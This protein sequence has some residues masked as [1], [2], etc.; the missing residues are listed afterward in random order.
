M[1]LSGRER[2][3]WAA[4]C[5]A[6]G[7]SLVG[8]GT[9]CLAINQSRRD[10]PAKAPVKSCPAQC[11]AAE[12]P[13]TLDPSGAHA[14]PLH[15]PSFAKR[16]GPSRTPPAFPES[17]HPGTALCTAT[18]LTNGEARGAQQDAAIPSRHNHTHIPRVRHLQQVQQAA[19]GRRLPIVIVVLQD[20]RPT[21]G[22]VCC[23]CS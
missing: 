1:R 7:A 15:F 18:R 4:S 10:M 16:E 20:G 9:P 17:P 3:H 13:H 8:V 23:T 22:V 2:L 11:G 6:D 21:G 14:T 19:A 12:H 5:Q